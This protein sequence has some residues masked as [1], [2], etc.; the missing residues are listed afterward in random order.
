[1]ATILGDEK[2]YGIEYYEEDDSVTGNHEHFSSYTWY[3]SKDERDQ[4]FNEGMTVLA[5]KN[6]EVAHEDAHTF[7]NF[8]VEIELKKTTIKRDL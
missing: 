8:K 5:Q 3:N 4:A 6:A 1:M 7:K 2:I